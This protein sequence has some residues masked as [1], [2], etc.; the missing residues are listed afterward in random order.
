MQLFLEVN[1]HPERSWMDMSTLQNMLEI[2]QSCQNWRAKTPKLL[3]KSIYLLQCYTPSNQW[4]ERHVKEL[5]PVVSRKSAAVP[6][7]ENLGVFFITISVVTCVSLQVTLF[8][9]FKLFMQFR[10][11]TV[12]ASLRN[13]FCKKPYCCKN[14]DYRICTERFLCSG[15]FQ[16]NTIANRS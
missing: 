12:S 11:S 15:A 16:W 13:T 14:N 1:G 8:V 9:K 10:T 7:T 2:L 3:C 6:D 5:E 4:I